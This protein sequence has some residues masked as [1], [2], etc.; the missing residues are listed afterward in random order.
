MSREAV[1]HGG[2]KLK[3]GGRIL[4]QH[5]GLSLVSYIIMGHLFMLPLTLRAKCINSNHSV[6]L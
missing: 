5:S 3:P 4:S 1:Y 2:S 6:A